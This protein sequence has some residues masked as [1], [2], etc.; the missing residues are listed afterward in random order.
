MERLA[1]LAQKLQINDEHFSNWSLKPK[2][3]INN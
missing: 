2:H 1:R 3:L